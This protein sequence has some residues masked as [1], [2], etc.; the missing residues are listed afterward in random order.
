MYTPLQRPT[1]VVPLGNA[2][3][4]YAAETHKAMPPED[5]FFW[6]MK[7]GG[8]IMHMRMECK[9]L[10]QSEVEEDSSRK[11]DKGGGKHM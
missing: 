1:P 4:G 10:A 6:Q 2:V 5:F 11:E 7:R 8:G 3:L 9:S